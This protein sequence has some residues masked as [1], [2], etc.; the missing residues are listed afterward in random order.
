MEER[1]FECDYKISSQTWPEM[2]D[3]M[4]A[5]HAHLG[6]KQKFNMASS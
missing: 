6:L 4:A 1:L 5:K 2:K 3:N